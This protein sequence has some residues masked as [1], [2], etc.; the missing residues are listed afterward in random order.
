MDLLPLELIQQIL[1]DLPDFESLQ[2][3]ILTSHRSLEAFN[4]REQWILRQILERTIPR[5]LRFDAQ[6]A[7]MASQLPLYQDW[8]GLKQVMEFYL[9]RDVQ[10]FHASFQ[11]RLS[12]CLALAKF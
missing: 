10:T 1:A 7:F 12:H 6:T 3:M 2:C 9:V 8:Q 5:A 11:P 4:D